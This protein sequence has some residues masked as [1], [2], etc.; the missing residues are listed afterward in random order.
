[1]AAAAPRLSPE[2]TARDQLRALKDAAAAESALARRLVQA[3]G[4]FGDPVFFPWLL[5]RCA[6]P[7]R[8]RVAGEAIARMTGIDLAYDDLDRDPPADFEGG[9]TDDPADD[10][11]APDPDADLPWPDPEKLAERIAVFTPP[12]AGRLLHGA[13]VSEAA[14]ALVSAPQRTRLAAA[15]EG[16]AARGGALFPCAAPAGRQRA[17]L[18]SQESG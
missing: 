18:A 10:D 2:Q 9:P 5:E 4:A 6:E 3:V 16:A 1:A 7:A 11:V 14:S 12:A 17:L 13:P 8:A 15:F